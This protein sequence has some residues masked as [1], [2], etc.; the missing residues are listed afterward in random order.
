MNSQ[1]NLYFLSV[2][3]A[4]CHQGVLT[5]FLSS[6][7]WT[8]N[9]QTTGHLVPWYWCHR[10]ELWYILLLKV[11]FAWALDISSQSLSHDY[12]RVFAELPKKHRFWAP[13][14]HIFIQELLGWGMGIW[15]FRGIAHVWE[16]P[17]LFIWEEI[18]TFSRIIY[19][20]DLIISMS[21]R[22]T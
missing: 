18:T 13:P 14:L 21:P 16:L 4:V 7:W 1:Q 9:F 5:F 15:Q 8:L 6:H 19:F 3:K 2:R 20:L 10:P 22:V 12:I 17:F 11:G